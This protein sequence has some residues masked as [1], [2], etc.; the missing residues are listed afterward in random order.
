[1]FIL[2]CI[3]VAGAIVSSLL[4]LSGVWSH[5]LN[6]PEKWAFGVNFSTSITLAVFFLLLPLAVGQRVLVGLDRSGLLVLLGLVPPICNLVFVV[7]AGSVGASP[8]L[9]ALGTSVGSVVT[10]VLFAT[11]AF[12]KSLGG[13]GSPL[14]A[15]SKRRGYTGQILHAAVPMLLVSLGTAA[16]I[17]SGRVVLAGHASV[18]D[19]SEYALAF[20][21]Y[22]PLYSVIYMASTVLWPRFAVSLN[23]R[24]WILANAALA[25]LG[26][27]AGI[28]YVVF[29]PALVSLMSD[30]EVSLSPGLSVGFALLI[31][32]QGLHAT[33][34]MLLTSV[35]GFWVQAGGAVGAGVLTLMLSVLLSSRYGV[36]GPAFAASI[37]LMVALVLPCLAIAFNLTRARP[38]F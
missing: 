2:L 9:L 3:G 23:R 35:R 16:A 37:G 17:Q 28:G 38:S 12:A 32:V 34:A 24:L 8:M 36:V 4:G 22:L 1:M 5:V 18:R 21:L 20:Q 33:Q 13:L 7:V 26:L 29:G 30:Q 15:N 19:L 31:T 6:A 14:S 25:G 11:F 27:C 10:V